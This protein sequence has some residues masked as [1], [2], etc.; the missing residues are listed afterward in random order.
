MQSCD[1]VARS[2]ILEGNI[3]SQGFERRLWNWVRRGHGFSRLCK[4]YT[5]VKS[6][7]VENRDM[8]SA[9]KSTLV[10]AY[11]FVPPLIRCAFKFKGKKL[12]M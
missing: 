9:S 6:D 1:D 10:Q 12:E 5:F 3:I 11:N 2:H 8:H 7:G 4:V